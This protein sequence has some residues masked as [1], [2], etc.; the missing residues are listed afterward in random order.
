[1]PFIHVYAWTGRDQEVK[2]ATAQSLVKSASAAMGAPEE[3]FTVI[4]EDVDKDA[5]EEQVQKA[6]IEPRKDKVIIDKGTL[7]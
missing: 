2:K 4:Y 3:A 6:I 5:W 7:V 1:M